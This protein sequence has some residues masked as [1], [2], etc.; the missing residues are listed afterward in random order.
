[1]EQADGLAAIQLPDGHSSCLALSKLGGGSFSKWRI[2]F[3]SKIQW[4]QF[5]AL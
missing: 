1:M 5:M 2:C 3:A 4:V